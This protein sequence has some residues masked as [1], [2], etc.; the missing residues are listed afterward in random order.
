MY[1]IETVES[2]NKQ[3]LTA[4][5]REFNGWPK[6]RVV[7]S[8]DQYEKRWTTHTN[9]GWPLLHPEVRELP[10]Y[11]QY[12]HQKYVLE[13]LVP[14]T[15]TTDLTENISYEPA[16]VFQHKTDGTYL[17]PRFDACKFVIEAIYSQID[18]AGQHRKFIDPETTA[19]GRHN[20]I[21]EV[22]EMLTGDE[23]S[24]GD[25]ISHGYGITVPEMPKTDTGEFPSVEIPFSVIS[26]KE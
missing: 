15:G 1:L 24:V 18:K 6:F 25:A 12:I 16:W 14:V 22:V 9:E 19:E 23:S 7:W 8:E 4:F 2:I 10:K 3:L 17:P 21:N 11:K 5:G 20:A 13:R 26:K